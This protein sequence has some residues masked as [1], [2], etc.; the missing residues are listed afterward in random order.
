MYQAMKTV[1][2]HVKDIKT[3]SFEF[4]KLWSLVSIGIRVVLTLMKSTRCYSLERMSDDQ[5]LIIYNYWT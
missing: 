1:L 4:T 3:R 2:L 5:K